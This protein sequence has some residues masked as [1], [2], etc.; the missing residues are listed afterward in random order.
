MDF[1]EGLPKSNGKDTILVVVDNL[2]KY[3]HLLAL[4]HPYSASS[5]EQNILD[6]VV[7]LHGAPS[8]IISDRNPIFFFSQF[9]KELFKTMGTQVKLSTAYH[10]QMDGQTERV[11]QCIEMYLRCLSSQKPKQWSYWLPL[12]DW[13]YNTTFHSAIGMYPYKALYSKAPPVV[14][15]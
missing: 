8:A 6:H 14:N 5:V 15:Y 1:V 9:L 2:T 10:P 7:K 13:L 3:C 4:S 12:A 11:N